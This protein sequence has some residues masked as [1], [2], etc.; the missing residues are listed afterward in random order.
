MYEAI[1]R[2]LALMGDIKRAKKFL[3][4]IHTTSLEIYFQ[5]QLV[6]GKMFA[7]YQDYLKNGKVDKDEIKQLLHESKQH[8]F[9]FFQRH[10]GQI[11]RMY[12]EMCY[13]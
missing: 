7:C 6:R 13:G 3:E 8:E 4:T 2:S 11:A 12:Q 9:H 1:S 10:R 5:S